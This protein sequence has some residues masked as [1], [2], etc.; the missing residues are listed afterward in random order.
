MFPSFFFQPPS[1]PISLHFLFLQQKK[2]EWKGNF[3]F[4]FYPQ[5]WTSIINGYLKEI[6]KSKKIKSFK[7][8]KIKSLILIRNGLIIL[9]FINEKN[10]SKMWQ[11]KEM[12]SK[13]IKILYSFLA[14]LCKG[15]QTLKMKVE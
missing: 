10:I 1:F 11:D 9:E 6:I 12:W 13:I 14:V 2:E 4:I 5:H 15:T 8:K 7:I 3:L